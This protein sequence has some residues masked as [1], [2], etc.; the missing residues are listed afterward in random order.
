M[1]W[2]GSI[3]WIYDPS[4][5]LYSS[6]V[7]ADLDW[8]GSEIHQ[9]SGFWIGLDRE[10]CKVY[11]IFR[12][13]KQFLLI[14]T[15]ASEV[16]SSK[17]SASYT[18]RRLFLHVDFTRYRVSNKKATQAF[19]SC[20][21]TRVPI[22]F[23]LTMDIVWKMAK[24]IVTKANSLGVLLHL[25]CVWLRRLHFCCFSLDSTVASQKV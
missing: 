6:P 11:L 16:P 5:D 24:I 8:T 9:L 7:Q 21:R 3:R 13:L 12:Y 18:H 19:G 25:E 2:T 20:S 15:L 10:M 17:S 14:A 23:K 1:E 4:M 22:L